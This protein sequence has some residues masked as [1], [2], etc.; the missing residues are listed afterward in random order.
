MTVTKRREN[1]KEKS[2]RI[3]TSGRLR[4]TSVQGNEIQAICRGDSG[5]VYNLRHTETD[6]PFWS[7]SCPARTACSHLYALWLVTAVDR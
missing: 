4:V 5:Q 2:L 7:C 3:V 6:V 1:V